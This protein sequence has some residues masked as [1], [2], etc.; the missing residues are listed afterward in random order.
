MVRA[1]ESH[2]FDFAALAFQPADRVDGA[3]GARV[4]LSFGYAVEVT[5]TPGGAPRRFGEFL[6]AFTAEK[7]AEGSD[8]G[9][10]FVQRYL[11]GECTTEDGIKGDS[12]LPRLTYN[13]RDWTYCAVPVL[14]LGGLSA[15]VHLSTAPCPGAAE[16]AEK[17]ADDSPQLADGSAEPLS[18]C[19]FSLSQ[20]HGC[21]VSVRVA[22]AEGWCVPR[23]SPRSYRRD[24]LPRCAHGPGAPWRISAGAR[25]TDRCGAAGSTSARAQVNLCE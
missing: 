24:R 19:D 20:P 22:I 12:V 6:A 18:I 15:N 4:T 23:Y 16:V 3:S 7:S 5:V 9:W 14:T 25:C 8:A 17:V 13:A 21:E 1:G 11:G 10:V 2:A